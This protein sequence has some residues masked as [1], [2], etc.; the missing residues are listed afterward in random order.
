MSI[1]NSISAPEK[2]F[3]TQG[4]QPVLILCDDFNFYVC[5]YNRWPG[6]EAKTLFNE[7]LAAS[8]AKLWNL[9][10]PEFRFVNINPSHVENFS[11]I[12]PAYFNTLCFGSRYNK[13][14]IDIDEFYAE[15][16]VTEKRRFRQK[17]D[18]LKIALFDLWLGNEDRNFNNYNLLIDI[19]NGYRF[20]PIDHVNIFNSGNPDK[21]PVLLTEEDSLISTALIRRLFSRNELLN[22]E[23]LTDIKNECYICIANCEKH[24]NDFLDIVPA[25]WNIDTN[26]YR[27][28]LSENLFSKVWIDACLKYF[29]EL[30]QHQI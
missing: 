16:S 28:L 12:Q 20:V 19:E 7:L 9:A 5:K 2:I 27:S 1:V 23:Y 29:L 24:V 21:K 22:R 4:S 13:K 8:F 18:F 6:S 3:E 26:K 25:G 10:V 30:I 14:F 15:I 17:T 11:E